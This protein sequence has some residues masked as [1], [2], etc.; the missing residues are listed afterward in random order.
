MT[1][2]RQVGTRKCV[3]LWRAERIFFCGDGLMSLVEQF[4]RNGLIES[5]KLDR[6]SEV[7][8]SEQQHESDQ[9]GD[10]GEKHNRRVPVRLSFRFFLA[11]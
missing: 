6:L 9:A 7:L 3:R 4:I 8:V 5:Q 2:G 10:K 1:Q 11:R